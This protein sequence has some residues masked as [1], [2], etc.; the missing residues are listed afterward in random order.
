MVVL[1]AF[2]V[3][4]LILG[5][6]S[7]EFSKEKEKAQSRGDFQRLRAKQQMEEDLQGY[8]DWITQA[9]EL[10][11]TEEANAIQVDISGAKKNSAVAGLLRSAMLPLQQIVDV[12]VT[13]KVTEETRKPRRHTRQ[14]AWQKRMKS[15]EKWNRKMRREARKICK[16]QWMFWLIVILVFL[17]TCVLATEHHDQPLWLDDFQEYTNLFFVCLF[18]CEMLLK[19][20]AL[21]F[22]G[23]MVSL[24]NR[25]DF[26][27]VVSSIMEFVLVNQE[28]MPPV[29]LSVLRCIRL[30]R[31]FKVTRYWAS[32]GN[33][34]KSLVNS[35][36]SINA[37]LVL[38]MLFI[39]IF[40]LL[41][42]QIFGGKFETESRSTFN[43]FYQSTFTVFQILTGE[44]W[45]VVM[46]DGIQAYGG[47]K[48]Y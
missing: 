37:L 48:N 11:A 9:E 29:G 43:G 41:G 20:Y 16:S 23:Y 13:A 26:V 27:V 22:S 36:A 47:V 34:V 21:G 12:T 4:N 28:L 10:E 38:L 30:L 24:F 19:M 3:M 14:T 5:V 46:Y 17:N 6:L 8:V 42:M 31:A 40:A 1:G 7:G 45:N 15:F 25:F 32:M 33:L 44:D 18:T 35:I 2:F 39:F